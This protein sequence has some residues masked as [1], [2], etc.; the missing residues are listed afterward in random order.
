[1]PFSRTAGAPDGESVSG[2]V[3]AS[4]AK[5][6]LQQVEPALELL[7]ARRKRRQ[8]PDDVSV[9]AA[10]EQEQSLLERCGGRG[11]RRVGRRL[12]QL[13]GEH[14]P[15]P[16]YLPHQRLSRR[17]LL[18]PRAKVRARMVGSLCKARGGQ[19]VED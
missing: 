17:D 12:A 4:V 5:C 15:E 7:V 19:F 10:R 14:R 9:E 8:Q 18:Q 1:M 13:E 2:A 6:L 16:A 11:L 3:G